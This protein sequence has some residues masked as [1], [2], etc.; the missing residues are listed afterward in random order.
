MRKLF[1]DLIKY[2]LLFLILLV[3]MGVLGNQFREYTYS[4]EEMLGPVVD[5]LLIRVGV[6]E[7]TTGISIQADSLTANEMLAQEI[8]F[9][10]AQLQ[11]QK[12]N[13]DLMEQIIAARE[14]SVDRIRQDMESRQMVLEQFEQ[15]NFAKLA[16]LF[17]GMVPEVAS[18]VLLQLP[19]DSAVEILYQMSD[20]EAGKL[21]EAIDP[22]RAA[23]IIERYR[24]RSGGG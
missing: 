2:M 3:V 1:A 5:D 7:D 9:T 22:V 19:D 21:I 23:D 24:R 20:R 13:L 10:M 12:D 4:I 11:E 16:K 14:D 15:D 6:K 17:E 8:S 18:Q